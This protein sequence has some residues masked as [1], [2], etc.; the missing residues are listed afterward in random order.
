MSADTH[1]QKPQDSS[2]KAGEKMSAER[3]KLAKKYENVHNGLFLVDIFYTI[4]L[5]L[6]FLFIG[7]Q[8]GVS[9]KMFGW[10]ETFCANY[11]LQVAL[12]SGLLTTAYM[13]CLLPLSFFSGYYLEHKYELSTQSFGSWLGDKGKS[14]ALNLLFMV[15][16][17]EVLYL[18]FTWTEQSWWIWVGIVWVLFGII[19]SNVA[20]VLIMPLFYKFKPLENDALKE[21]LVKMAERLNVKIFGVFEMELSSKTKKANAALAGLGNTK[22]ILLG[23]T[24][25]KNFTDEEIEVVLA[26]ELGH[27]CYKHIWQLI[28]FG[29]AITFAGLFLVSLIFDNLVIATGFAGIT[30]IPAFPLF[31]LCMFL[32]TLIS[33]PVNATFTRILEKQADN[34]ALRQTNAPDHFIST[35]KKLADLNLAD[36]E[37]HPV[38]EFLMHDHPSISSRVKVAERY[39]KR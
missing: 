14:Y 24:L 30:D 39:S 25:L 29:G 27:Y 17:A 16:I 6:A 23:D 21:R 11:W 2:S 7:E 10:I 33:M 36:E 28:L 31:L 35:M 38:I 3:K 19:L 22:R 20:P 15:F 1:V 4:V 37:P 18:F 32:F 13:A 8:G 5:I 26:H 34:F 9:G 12:Y